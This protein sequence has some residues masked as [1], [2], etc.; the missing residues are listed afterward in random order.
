VVAIVVDD[1]LVEPGLPELVVSNVAS[2][3]FLPTLQFPAGQIWYG[4]QIVAQDTNLNEAIVGAEDF[5]SNLP[6]FVAFNLQTGKVTTFPTVK[7]GFGPF[8]GIAIDST[9]DTMCTTTG[10][11]YNVEFYNLK[12]H[13]GISETLPG[14]GGELAAGA[15]IAADPVNHLFLVTQ[16]DS[17][18]SP[19]GGSTIFVYDEKGTLVETLNGFSFPNVGSAVYERVEV[20]ASKRVGYVNGPL[21]NEL[22]S[23][24]Y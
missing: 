1:D 22:Q 12:T 20:N 17:S 7:N 21:A 18:V 2:D 10:A 4:P 11:D 3:T 16:P 5:S 14:A 24:S 15:A 9:T 13:K 6:D 23:F 19:S 8:E